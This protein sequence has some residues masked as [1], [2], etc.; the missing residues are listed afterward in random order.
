VVPVPAPISVAP[1]FAEAMGVLPA[2]VLALEVKFRCGGC[3]CKLQIDA[4]YEGRSVECPEC[5]HEARVPIWS[6]RLAPPGRLIAA[7]I[8]FLT[9]PAEGVDRHAVIAASANATG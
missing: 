8:D 9:A 6:R 5:R 4:R 7:E 1:E 3:S 2:G